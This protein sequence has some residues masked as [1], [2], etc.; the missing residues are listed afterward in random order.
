MEERIRQ[1]RKA[2]GLN[3]REFGARIGVKQTSVAGY[4]S[5][6]RTPLEAVISAMVREFRVSEE[7][8]RTGAGE[9]FPPVDPEEELA[10]FLGQVTFGG[11]SFQRR[12]LTALARLDEDG[13]RALERLARSL[14][15][16]P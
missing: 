15:E 10:R 14:A 4:E 2:L 7:W 11:E 16:A 6:A 12:L 1:L 8:L 3:Q 5:G 9:M 13:W